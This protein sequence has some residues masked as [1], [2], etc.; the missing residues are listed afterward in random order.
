[1]WIWL[2]LLSLLSP[3]SAF[4]L[5]EEAICSSPNVI[6]CENW[7]D[8]PLSSDIR[9]TFAAGNMIPNIGGKTLGW[10][11]DNSPGQ[12]IVSAGCLE[13]N[14]FAQLYAQTPHVGD[15]GGGGFIGTPAIGNIQ[16]VYYRIWIKYPSN[17]VESSNG[18]K[19]I[20]AEG[21][22]PR[23]LIDADPAGFPTSERAQ[24][25]TTSVGCAQDPFATLGE[26]RLHVNMNPSFSG[27][28]LGQWQC[29]EW[30][31]THETT[32]LPT[33]SKDGVLEA[34][35]NDPSGGPDVQV[36]G[37]SGISFNDSDSTYQNG[38]FYTDY[39]ISS[40]WNCGVTSNCLDAGNAHPDM[41]RLIDRV[42]ISR[43]RIGCGGG[44][45]APTP[46]GAPINLSVS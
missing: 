18:S 32:V 20:Y 40:Y 31:I 6:F 4:A 14:C 7:N 28:R 27:I 19:V 16:T 44:G 30:R 37:F 11:Y 21:T 34:W 24:C 41:T 43:A 33:N 10:F 17:W 29:L 15:N 1:M 46:P 42:V 22:S 35:V 13:G 8:R 39:L 3:L 12:Q 45:T 2:L 38:S 36:M 23:Q 25:Y 26:T 9:V 5:T